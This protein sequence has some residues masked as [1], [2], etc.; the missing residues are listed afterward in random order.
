[1]DAAKRKVCNTSMMLTT[2]QL[3]VIKLQN[4]RILAVPH[5]KQNGNVQKCMKPKS[6]TGKGHVMIDWISWSIILFQEES[7]TKWTNTKGSNIN[8]IPRLKSKLSLIVYKTN[9]ATAI[10]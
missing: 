7:V 10:L 8:R 4:S 3:Q 6:M 1:M 2:D 5:I 9:A